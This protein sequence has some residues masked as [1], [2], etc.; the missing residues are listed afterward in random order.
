MLVT[1]LLAQADVETAVDHLTRLILEED[2]T[3]VR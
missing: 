2:D 3:Q 1:G